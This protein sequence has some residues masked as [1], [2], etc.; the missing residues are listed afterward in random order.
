M[1]SNPF[2]QD[3]LSVVIT[4]ISPAAAGALAQGINQNVAVDPTNNLLT[5]LLGNTD[6]NAGV[7]M[8]VGLNNNPAF[9]RELIENI[10]APTAIAIAQGINLSCQRAHADPNYLSLIHI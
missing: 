3:L 6:G 5:G 1:A 2:G 8:A 4:N 9:I 7:A 10:T